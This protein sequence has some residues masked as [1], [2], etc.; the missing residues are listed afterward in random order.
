MSARSSN[1]SA[2]YRQRRLTSELELTPRGQAGWALTNIC[3]KE[4]IY[5]YKCPCRCPRFVIGLMATNDDELSIGP[6]LKV[7]RI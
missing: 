6:G 2:T 1:V 3:G 5:V 4:E 7:G